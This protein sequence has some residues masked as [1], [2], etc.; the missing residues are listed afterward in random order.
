MQ[1]KLYTR[2]NCSLCDYSKK[3]LQKNN[4]PYTEVLIDEQISREDI[5]KKYPDA[6]MLP[7]IVVD[8]TWIGGRDDL[9]RMLKQGQL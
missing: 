2:R 9:V 5:K 4:L 1:I 8:G 3:E 7:I 6:K